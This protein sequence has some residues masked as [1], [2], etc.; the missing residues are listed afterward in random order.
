MNNKI[1]YVIAAGSSY[2]DVT[3]EEWKYLEDKHTI[4]F[5]RVP[6]G[7]RKTEYYFSIERD[8]T[9]KSVLKYMAKLGYLDTKLLLYIPQSIK[10]ARELG[11][12]S[13]RK[14]LKQSVLFLPSRQPWFMDESEPP[15][16][17]IEC[18]AKNFHQPI[19]RYRGQLIAVIN[20]CLILGATEIRLIGVDLNDQWNFYDNYDYL[21]RVCKDK[22]TIDVYKKHNSSRMVKD[23]YAGKKDENP[24]YDPTKMHTT[25]MPIYN[26]DRWGNRPIRGVAD[27]VQWMNKEMIEE[28][29]EGIFITNKN[30]LLYK[31][32]KL[33]YR[34]IIDGT[35]KK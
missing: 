15:H 20:A 12:K 27:L 28:G 31:E 19:F 22:Y 33:R 4:T 32:N 10:L 17:F 14:I 16:K 25:N 21:E 2:M 3:E 9:D 8:Y 35:D 24:D 23:R 34:G 7:S 29:M 5:A 18:R 30:S 1:S 6:Y 11:F 26:R 13:I